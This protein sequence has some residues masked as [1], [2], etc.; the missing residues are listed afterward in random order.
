MRKLQISGERVHLLQKVYRKEKDPLEAVACTIFAVLFFLYVYL[1]LESKFRYEEPSTAFLLGL[2]VPFLICCGLTY[3]AY[4]KLKEGSQLER[5]NLYANICICAWLAFIAGA[6]LGNKSFWLYTTNIYSYRDLVGYVDIDPYADRGQAYMDSGHVYFK[7]HSYVL[8]QMF[9]KFMNGD[10]YCVAPIVR[11]SVTATVAEESTQSTQLIAK[12]KVLV[13]VGTQAVGVAPT[14]TL[15]QTPPAAA[16]SATKY[17]IPSSGTYDWWAVGV[18]CCDGNT[19][20]DFKCG[21]VNDPRSR[22]G[23]RLL[24]DTTRPF[25]LLAVQEWSA[26]YGLPVKHPLFFTWVKDPLETENQLD[27]QADA[28]LWWYVFYTAIIGFIFS[29]IFHVVMHQNKIY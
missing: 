5:R 9:T 10:Q 6:G 1:V 17:G 23:M 25:Y 14:Q 24:S 29:F 28:D 12:S 2:V 21:E 15:V 16:T 13:P 4:K 19:A 18:N 8:R 22:S 26:T 20:A 27:N 7:E 11:G 3:M